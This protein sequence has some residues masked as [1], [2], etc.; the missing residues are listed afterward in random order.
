[1]REAVDAAYAQL[2]A[3]RPEHRIYWEF[4]EEERNNL[5]KV[6][7]F[8]VQQNVTVRPGGVWWN[9]ATGES[10]ADRPG[11]TTYEHLVR[12]GSSVGQD[13]RD[14]QPFSVWSCLTIGARR[15]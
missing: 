1:L 8:G 3:T 14:G 15:L 10:G 11:S 6:Y 5:L 13:P 12:G 4:I 7:E 2:K 9:P